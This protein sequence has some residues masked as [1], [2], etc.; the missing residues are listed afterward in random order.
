VLRDVGSALLANH[1]LVTV[2]ATPAAALH[3][4]GVV[5]HCARV[6]WGVQALGGYVPLPAG[7]LERLGDVYRRSRAHPPTP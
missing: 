6:A 3:Q 5:E 1:G 4:A 2:A 7:A